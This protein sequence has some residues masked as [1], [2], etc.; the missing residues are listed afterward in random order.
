MSAL[1]HVGVD[2][3]DWTGRRDLAT[4]GTNSGSAVLPFQGWRRFK[5][6]FAP[7]LIERAYTETGDVRHIVDPFGGSGTTALAAQ[8]LGAHPTTIEV[9]PFLADLIEAKVCRYDLDLLVSSY[10]KV[11]DEARGQS[12]PPEPYF[13]NAP[14]TFLEPGVG[15]RFLFSKDVASRLCAYRKAIEALQDEPSKRLMRVMLASVAVPVSNA[16]ISGKGRRYKNNWRERMVEPAVIDNLFD[17]GVLSAICDLR[18]YQSRRCR[19]YTLR[20]GDSREL[21]AEVEAFD[22]AIFSP[23]YPNSF[24]YTDVYNIELWA[25]GYLNGSDDNKTLRSATLRSHVQVARDFSAAMPRGVLVGETVE[26]LARHRAK[27]W[28]RHIPEMVGAYFDDMSRVLA[29]LRSKI[30]EGGR[31]YMVV[32]DSRYAGVDVPVAEALV[33]EAPTLGYKVLSSEP[34]RS[35]RASPQQGGRAELAESLV[36]LSA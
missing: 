1:A 14:P 36:V 5:E 29:G 16:N 30:R 28:N 9:N 17:Q 20:R 13:A 24:D 18:S 33:A 31:V 11:M 34:F 27:L 19:E 10:A 2:F 21:A 6:A 8:F 4:I 22:L 35:M 15:E 25:L 26:A 23:P 32:G 12:V 7:E 3:E